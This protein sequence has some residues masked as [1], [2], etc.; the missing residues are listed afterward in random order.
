[1]PRHRETQKLS[2]V[3]RFKYTAAQVLEEFYLQAILPK[4]PLQHL[5]MNNITVTRGDIHTS[6][7]FL[8]VVSFNAVNYTLNADCEQSWFSEYGLKIADPSTP[9]TLMDPVI[10]VSSDRLVTSRCVNLN[11]EIICD[12]AK[13][14]HYSHVSMFRVMNETAAT[15]DVSNE[16]TPSL[17]LSDQFWWLFA[18]FIVI[19]FIF[20][21]FMLCKRIF[22]CFPKA[23]PSVCQR[24]DSENKILNLVTK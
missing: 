20:I 19:F 2:H 22:R 13:S 6:L 11:H 24:N 17:Q 3:K 15:P 1:M 10:S 12:S 21:S 16:V 18:L 5:I 8:Y 9:E 14:L 23:A 7:G 4:D